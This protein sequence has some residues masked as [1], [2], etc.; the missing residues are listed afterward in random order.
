MAGRPPE[1]AR[2]WPACRVSRVFPR[3]FC[4]LRLRSPPGPSSSPASRLPSLA[5][6]SPAFPTGLRG[7]ARVGGPR[8][9]SCAAAP[10]FVGLGAR[11]RWRLAPPPPP[12]RP[13]RCGSRGRVPARVPAP[14]GGTLGGF[15]LPLLFL[16]DARRRVL[17]KKLLFLPTPLGLGR[18]R[19]LEG[20]GVPSQVPPFIVRSSGVRG[21]GDRDSTARLAP[22]PVPGLQA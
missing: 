8:R 3:P 16:G 22:S 20:L 6:P 15:S 9:R 21:R 2:H 12:A 18:G 5:F 11:G 1:L 17:R 10:R 7:L 14:G 4:F 13:R 19:R